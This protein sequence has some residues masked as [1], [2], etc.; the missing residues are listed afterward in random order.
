M[1]NNWFG[2]APTYGVGHGIRD[3]LPGDTVIDSLLVGPAMVASD[4]L[5]RLIN[6]VICDHLGLVVTHD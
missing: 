4:K 3:N 6:D 2:A 1:G 5:A